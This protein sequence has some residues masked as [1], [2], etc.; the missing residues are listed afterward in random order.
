MKTLH[1]PQRCQVIW[2]GC[3]IT[4]VQLGPHTW[5]VEQVIDQYILCDIW[6]HQPQ[7][8]GERRVYYLLDTARGLLEV[9]ERQAGPPHQLGWWIAGWPD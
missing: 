5:P 2:Q 7:A 1:T 6:R 4:A 9:F 3:R 8:G